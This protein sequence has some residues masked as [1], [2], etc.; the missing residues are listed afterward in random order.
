MST[1]TDHKHVFDLHDA[2]KDLGWLRMATSQLTDSTAQTDV[3]L[4]RR[5]L[6]NGEELLSCS[7]S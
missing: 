4:L 3:K 1:H 7:S 6:V 2:D 5:K